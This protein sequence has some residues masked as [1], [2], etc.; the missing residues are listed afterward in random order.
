MVMQVVS[1]FEEVDFLRSVFGYNLYVFI[2]VPYI[3]P[4]APV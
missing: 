2:S 4:G 3:N 1:E